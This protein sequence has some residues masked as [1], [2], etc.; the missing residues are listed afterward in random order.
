MDGKARVKIGSF[1]R[2]G[3]SRNGAKADDHD[4]NPKTTVTLKQSSKIFSA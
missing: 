1:D 3:K 4:F 2:G